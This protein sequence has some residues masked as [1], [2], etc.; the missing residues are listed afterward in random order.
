MNTEAPQ[1]QK[2]GGG[3]PDIFIDTIDMFEGPGATTTGAQGAPA[4]KGLI[5]DTADEAGISGQPESGI[6]IETAAE[7]AGVIKPDYSRR[8]GILQ[9]WVLKAVEIK[10]L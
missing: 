4:D 9:A 8:P 3:E 6:I 7:E 1:A 10:M 2:E 5:I